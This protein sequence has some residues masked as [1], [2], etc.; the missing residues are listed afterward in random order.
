ML[1]GILVVVLAVS[2]YSQVLGQSAELEQECHILK[3]LDT[4]ET[5]LREQ[6]ARL[7]LQEVLLQQQKALNDQ[8]E[9]RLEEQEVLLQQ[10][11]ALNDQQEA[12][13]EQQ[14][15]L[16]EQQTAS[17]ESQEAR[18]HELEANSSKQLTGRVDGNILHYEY[19]TLHYLIEVN[20]GSGAVPRR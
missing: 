3:T 12:R 1:I 4:L 5:R 16:L 17:L 14:D 18:I 20:S 11:K 9:A 7:K 10:Q 15:N 6:D 19:S 13:L 8:Q 2:M